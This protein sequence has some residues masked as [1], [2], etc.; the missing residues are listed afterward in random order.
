MEPEGSLQH[1]LVPANSPYPDP[2]RSNPCPTSH[3]LKINLNIILPSTPGSF[4]WFLSLRSPNKILYAP[5]LSHMRVTGPAHLILKLKLVKLNTLEKCCDVSNI[6]F[7]KLKFMY[8]RFSVHTHSHKGRMQGNYVPLHRKSSASITFHLS[9]P[10]P[11]FYP[12]QV[13]SFPQIPHQNPVYTYSLPHTCYRSNP[14][15]PETEIS[16]A[17]YTCKILWYQ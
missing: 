15:Y 6:W 3:I 17:E 12:S 1:S 4:K 11:S 14:S 2:A 5:I 10:F 7:Q 13:V 8:F 16:E 9:S